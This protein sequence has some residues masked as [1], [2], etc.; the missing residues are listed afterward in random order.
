MWLIRH[1]DSQIANSDANVIYTGDIHHRTLPIALG[2]IGG[3]LLADR[4]ESNLWC[5]TKVGFS[6]SRGWFPGWLE[7]FGWPSYDS[8]SRHDG[9]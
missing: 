7:I 2:A 8:V 9:R 1:E 5:R 3:P 6:S 4:R